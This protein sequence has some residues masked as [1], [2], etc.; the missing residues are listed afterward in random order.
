VHIA[1]LS[2]IHM[3]HGE[4]VVRMIRV[5]PNVGWILIIFNT[6]LSRVFEKGIKCPDF[7][8]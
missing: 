6:H 8:S 7:G 4:I 5:C 2:G 1:D 3:Y